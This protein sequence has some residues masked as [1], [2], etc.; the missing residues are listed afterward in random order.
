MSDDDVELP[1]LWNIEQASSYLHECPRS[2]R[3]RLQRGELSAI[4]LPGSRRL[5]FNPATVRRF[6][7]AN[8]RPGS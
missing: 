6:V 1:E 8:E 2:T 5:L 4:R 3:R 7:V